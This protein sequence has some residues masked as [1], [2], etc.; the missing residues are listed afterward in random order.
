MKRILACLFIVAVLPSIS[1]SLQHRRASGGPLTTVALAGHSVS[2]SGRAECTCELGADGVCPCCG[3]SINFI[4]TQDV[5]DGADVQPKL[6]APAQPDSASGLGSGELLFVL[7]MIA[8]SR[9]LP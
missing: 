9:M 5:V 1:P 7:A 2:S 3:Y 6:S 4:R 8:W